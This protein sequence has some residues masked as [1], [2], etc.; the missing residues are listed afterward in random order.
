MIKAGIFDAGGVLHVY[1]DNDSHIK[2]DIQKT[3]GISPDVF[4]K[5]WKN[6]TPLLQRGE[7]VEDEYW[8]RFLSATQTAKSLPKESLLVREFSKAFSPRQDVL[9]IGFRFY[10]IQFCLM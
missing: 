2:N 8:K 5:A 7:I 9:A 3:L 10:L 4:E 1:D 6:I